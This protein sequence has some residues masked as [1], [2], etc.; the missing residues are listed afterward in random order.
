MRDGNEALG[1]LAGNEVHARY[2]M[3]KD[4]IAHFDS[5]ANDG[6]RNAGFGLQIIG[7]Q[8]VIDI[9]C[10]RH[11]LAH[12]VS[13]NPFLPPKQPKTWTPISSAGAGKPEPLEDLNETISPHVGPC[14]DL[15]KAIHEDRQPLCDVY[16]GAMTVETPAFTVHALRGQFELHVDDMGETTL[17]VTEGRVEVNE[18]GSFSLVLPREGGRTQ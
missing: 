16:E 6:T 15:I 7:S 18:N 12:L 2:R 4:I 13:G 11:P 17:I 10:D 3:E 14:R 9:K 5:I 8:G 1:P